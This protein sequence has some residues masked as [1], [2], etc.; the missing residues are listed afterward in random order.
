LLKR[1]MTEIAFPLLKTCEVPVN[2]V[3][4][5]LLR[6]NTMP[7]VVGRGLQFDQAAIERTFIVTGDL[8][9]LRDEFGLK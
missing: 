1:L 8:Q 4:A 5:H 2:V 7:Q 9:K 6:Y 3:K